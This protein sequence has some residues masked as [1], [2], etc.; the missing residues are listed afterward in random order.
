MLTVLSCRDRRPCSPQEEAQEEA[1][2]Q[3]AEADRLRRIRVEDSE[4]SENEEDTVKREAEKE[5]DEAHMNA[6][7]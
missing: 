5:A 2:R 4:E 7:A 3:A 6:P 1:R